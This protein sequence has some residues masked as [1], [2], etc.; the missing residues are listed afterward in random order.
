MFR[1][2]VAVKWSDE[3]NGFI[4][5]VPELEG[6]SAF[7]ETQDEA[8][9][10]LLVAA[11]AYMESLKESGQEIPSPSKMGS[12]SGQLR[13]RMPKWLHAKLAMEAENEGISLNMHLVSLLANRH[14]E[15]ETVNA[16]IKNAIDA[17][18][19]TFQA[20]PFNIGEEKNWADDT[21]IQNIIEGHRLTADTL[22]VV[23][24]GKS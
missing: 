9:K 23:V 8:V 14:G 17:V 6:L 2:S 19:D 3:D 21:T 4:A 13:L 22:Y 15:H 12:Y 7:G 1:H 20:S 10:E 18:K 24:G 16:F 5:F 11:E